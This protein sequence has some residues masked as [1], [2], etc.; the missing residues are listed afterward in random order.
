MYLHIVFAND[1]LACREVHSLR[2]S[3]GTPTMKAV[4]SCFFQCSLLKE[5]FPGYLAVLIV[6][7]FVAAQVPAD[8]VI[9]HW[10]PEV[11]GI[12]VL[13]NPVVLHKREE[14]Q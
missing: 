3:N 13:P 10:R 12:N 4:S 5:T 11:F 2:P 6:A 7:P 8:F 1:S 14:V 9:V